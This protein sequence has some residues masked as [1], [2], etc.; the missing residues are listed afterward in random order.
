MPANDF[1]QQKKKTFITLFTEQFIFEANKVL[2]N[3][4][5]TPPRLSNCQ[6]C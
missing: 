4:K 1:P 6:K 2:I 5:A 3:V